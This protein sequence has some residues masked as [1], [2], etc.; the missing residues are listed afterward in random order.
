MGIPCR[1]KP[2][3]ARQP[4]GH[5]LRD[6]RMGIPC[7]AKL[8]GARRP[9]GHALRDARMGIPCRAKPDGARRPEGVNDSI[10]RKRGKMLCILAIF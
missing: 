4:E 10:N 3:G 1:A 6:A 9:E 8:D 2:D 5:A 7:R